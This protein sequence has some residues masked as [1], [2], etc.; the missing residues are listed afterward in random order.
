MEKCTFL[1]L[2][3]A[4]VGEALEAVQSVVS[5][6]MW[7]I[8]SALS[9]GKRTAQLPATSSFDHLIGAKQQGRGHREAEGLRGLRV[10]DELELCRLLDR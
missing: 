3:H 5:R 4:G 1:Y 8:E 9:G 10:D 7:K 6:L 2:C